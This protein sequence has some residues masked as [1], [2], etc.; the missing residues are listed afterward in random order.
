MMYIKVLIAA[1]LLSSCAASGT[2]FSEIQSNTFNK[3]LMT[4]VWAESVDTSLACDAKNLHNS[5]EFADEDKTLIFK[6]DRLWKI[7]NEKSVT[8]YSAKII[9]SSNNSLTI[10]Y[11]DT[12]GLPDG[13]P[14]EWD[15]IF[16]AD[17]VYR[18][19]ASSWPDNK[20]NSVVGI[21]CSK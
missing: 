2:K 11:D 18:W 10:A 13:Y 15:I 8:Q 12:L 9:K 16:V 20:V 3:S 1:A 21:R 5:F 4:G 14:T 6:L 19:K 17:G 7:A